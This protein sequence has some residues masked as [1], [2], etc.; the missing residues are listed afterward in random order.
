[1]GGELRFEPSSLRLPTL[2]FQL[3]ELLRNTAE[4]GHRLLCT[5]CA[6]AERGMLVKDRTEK[7]AVVTDR[8]DLWDSV[9]EILF[10]GAGVNLFVNYTLMQCIILIIT[11]CYSS[12][13][14][15]LSKILTGVC[16]HAHMHTCLLAWCLRYSCVCCLMSTDEE[17]KSK[18]TYD[19]WLFALLCA[20]FVLFWFLYNYNLLSERHY[21]NL[22]NFPLIY[23]YSIVTM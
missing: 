15:D 21:L 10:K 18:N 11:C 8:T 19:V 13:L 3:T 20:I 14:S 1:M 23:D 4:P 9:R 16:G 17:V 7:V 22:K 6:M 12:G 5:D 2:P